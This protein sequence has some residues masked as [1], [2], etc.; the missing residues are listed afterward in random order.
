MEKRVILAFALSLLILV[1]FQFAVSK[2][3]PQARA[4]VRQNTTVASPVAQDTAAGQAAAFLPSAVEEQ[5]AA[6]VEE[7]EVIFEN[8]LYKVVFSDLGAGIKKITLKENPKNGLNIDYGAFV[9][10]TPREYLFHFFPDAF[11]SVLNRV[12]YEYQVT[13]NEVVFTYPNHNNE[14]MVEK[15]FRFSNSLYY[16]QLDI[17]LRNLQGTEIKK[18]F[19]IGA[20]HHRSYSAAEDKFSELSANIDGMV[21]KT[22][23]QAKPF[24]LPKV[25]SVNLV[26]QKERYFAMITQPLITCSG[27]IVKQNSAGDLQTY[28]NINEFAIPPDS[29]VT[30][31][32]VTYFGPIDLGLIKDAG[33][34]S[35]NVLAAGFFASLTQ[36][37]MGG[38]KF[39]FICC[40]NWGVAI[41]VLSVLMNLILFPLTRKSYKSMQEIQI[42]QPKIEKLRKEHKDN[43]QKMQKELMELYRKYKVNPMGGCLPMLLQMPIFIALYQGLMHSIHLRGARF[44]WVKDLSSQENIPIPFTLPVLGNSFNILPI[45]MLVAMYLQQRMSNKITSI[46]QTDE[47]RQQQK[48]MAVMMT[49]MFALIFYSM[50]SGLV[51]YWLA[52]T[53]LMTV[54]QMFFMKPHIKAEENA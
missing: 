39:L 19:A 30:Q 34:G 52:N 47:Q 10:K 32:F 37:L 16:I 7:Q 28:L 9:A 49:V 21:L 2:W 45:L 53:V 46:T 15:R 51:L 23:K 13:G 8:S 14:F 5:V 3:Y 36:L 1:G 44:L 38:L 54:L 33:I 27:Y 6:P 35:N 11:G 40:R 22:R 31:K 50:P 29:V 4:P 41:I 43:P 26:M 20:T 25:G 24:E 12:N 18:Q 48:F 42:L 17:T